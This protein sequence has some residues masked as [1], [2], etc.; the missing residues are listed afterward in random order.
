VIERREEAVHAVAKRT[1][2]RERIDQLRRT[3]MSQTAEKQRVIGV[4][5]YDDWALVLPPPP[6]RKVIK[7]M[8]AS[9]VEITDVLL[10]GYSPESNHPSGG[11]F[12]PAIV[13]RNF[14][15][16]LEVHPAYVDPFSSLAGAYMT[17]FFSYRTPHWNP[18]LRFDFLAPLHSLYKIAHG[19]G[20]VQH[21]CHDF[22]LGL[23]LGWGGLM[24]KMRDGRARNGA[25]AGPF[26]QGLEDV[27]LGAQSWIGRTAAEA[28]QR[29]GSES[30]PERAENLR[31]MARINAR[32]VEE[33]PG[34]FREACQWM[35]WYLMMARMYDGSG[36]LGRL[37]LILQPYY[38]RDVAA[39]RLDDEEA[40]FHIAC[41]LLR[42]TSYIQVGGIDAEGRDDSSRVS[43]LVLE[44][45]NMLRI[46]ANVGVAV[47]EHID[48]ELLRRSSRMILANKNGVP[49]F[50][51]VDQT[52][53]GFARNGYPLALGYQRVYSGCHWSAIPGREYTMNDMV[54]INMGVVF[55]VA[56]R[57]MA[58]DSRSPGT[59]N[60]WS[61]FEKHL[62]VAVDAVARGLDFHMAHMAEVFPELV[63]DLL[64]HGPL[65]KGLDAAA[66][67][68]E[69]VN[70]GVDAA[71]LGTV[72]DSFS[73]LQ[74][75]VEIERRYTW[76]QILALLD[77]D[78]AGPGGEKARLMM[79]NSPRY[80]S[81]DSI[82]D[83]WA[84]R[85]AQSFTGIVKEKT[86]PD[87]YAMLP[88]LFSWALVIGMGKE[89]GATPNGR[90]AG[91]VISQG[92][93]PNPGFRSD[94]AATAM[95]DAI[96]RVQPGYGNTAPMQIDIDP[97][98]AK[99][100]D[101]AAIVES[102]V[103]TH[104]ALGGTQ[105][106]MNVV[107]AKK[108]ME[109]NKDPSRFPDLVVRVTGF[110]AFFASLSPELRQFVVDRMLREG[111]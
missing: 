46:P 4:M 36:A 27:I 47:G 55:D 12:G 91:D 67:G 111:A 92:A 76:A 25:K 22:T 68:V 85:I 53:R 75:R 34:T 26:Y 52:A 51:G 10:E 88:G 83:G 97:G 89:L 102:L 101:G 79:K 16:L 21:F 37:D 43:H 108:V 38:E 8:G 78:W 66:G 56:L 54:K 11:F 23:Q 5:D 31:E 100:S 9:G 58:A 70:L 90:H 39:G 98:L 28:A 80:G 64:C 45:A 33:P 6:L 32:L 99:E 84:Q 7:T 86:T 74:Q 81:G 1:T 62:R 14:R 41:M 73:A 110:S 35:L 69:F 65:E 42:D 103:R 57:E 18:D 82:A 59:E 29:A 106:N 44:A 2:Y 105:I 24:Q 61:R 49:K 13:G 17:N 109:A 63:L 20:G 3:K 15:R 50:L 71:A 77:S 94:A 48:P 60:L 40:I 95:A 19:I 87:G 107:D 96:A 30:D 93:N 72:A 104:F